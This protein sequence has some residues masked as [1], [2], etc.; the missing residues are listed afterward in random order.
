MF[1]SMFGLWS[2]MNYVLTPIRFI[3]FM[4]VLWGF[5]HIVGFMNDETAIQSFL[6]MSI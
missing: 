2:F 6:L 3:L 4:I 1:V 5:I